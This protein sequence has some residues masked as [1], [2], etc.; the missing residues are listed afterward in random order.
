MRLFPQKL[1][2]VVLTLAPLHANAES[3]IEILPSS[4]DAQADTQKDALVVLPGA[5]ENALQS[6]QRVGASTIVTFDLMIGS[7]ITGARIG[8]RV[9]SDESKAIVLEALAGEGFTSAGFNTTYGAGARLVLTLAEDRPHRNALLVSPG[10]DVYVLTTTPGEG[11]TDALVPY[12]NVYFVGANVDVEYVHQFAA[13]FGWDI[14]LH[15]GAAVGVSG[16]GTTG[17]D[18]VGSIS[19]EVSLFTGFRF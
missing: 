2:A 10:L 8:G 14:G 13:H 16:I 1:I 6:S 7:M 18:A 3:M 11:G 12:T 17:A 4:R 5:L 15:G 9:W 19:P